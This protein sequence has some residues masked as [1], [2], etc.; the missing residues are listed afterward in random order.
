MS[1]KSSIE[2]RVRRK[3]GIRKKLFGTAERPRV[4]VY[5]SLSHIYAQAVDDLNGTTIA[6]ASSLNDSIVA[7]LIDG[8]GKVSVG[9][10]VGKA[11]ATRLKEKD[12]ASAIFD[13]NGYL[14][15]GRV[16]AVAE[17]AREGG[18]QL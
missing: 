2:R 12:V 18:L 5:R 6:H 1:A 7:G 15:H 17:G 8:K 9:K 10:A 16:K 3:R 11:I 14:Y 4:T 13:R